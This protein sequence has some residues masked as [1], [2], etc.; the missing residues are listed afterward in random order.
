MNKI[1]KIGHTSKNYSQKR[2]IVNKISDAKYVD[3]RFLNLYFWK[4]IHVWA[5]WYLKMTKSNAETYIR[6]FLKFKMIFRGLSKFYVLHFYNTINFS[7]RIPWVVTIETC[8]PFNRLLLDSIQSKNPDF[9]G[10]NQDQNTRKAIELIDDKSCIGLLAMSQCTYNIQ[11]EILSYFP[12]YAENIK[13]KTIVLHPPQELLINKIE[14]K[15]ISYNDDELTRFIFIGRDF[16][17][18]GGSQILSVLERFKK[19]HK[20]EVILISEINT[21]KNF[22]HFTKAD[23]ENTLKYISENGDWIKYCPSL[24]NDHVLELIK[25][26]HVALLPTWMDTY[27]YS[28][29]ECQSGGCPVITT[30]VRA[31]TEINNDELGWVI[32]VPLNRLKHPIHNSLEEFNKFKSI[33][34]NGLELAFNDIFNNK[35]KIKE[36]AS[37]CIKTV[38]LNN[39]PADYSEVLDKVYSGALKDENILQP[40]V[41]PLQKS[42]I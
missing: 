13:K 23:S 17:R 39:N 19:Q 42:R 30:N 36:K 40:L 28:V 38:S 25:Q 31:L 34:E 11:M 3:I 16:F 27:G 29:L 2:Y 10:I 4:N 24:S 5:L 35:H 22:A 15:G 1:K 26:S 20:F 41:S 18:K 7:S 6:L 33:L 12:E 14:E 8:L 32:P 37:K 9:S 21:K